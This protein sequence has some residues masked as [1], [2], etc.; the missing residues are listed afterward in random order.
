[1]KKFFLL[2]ALLC[3]LVVGSVSAQNMSIT[4][5]GIAS[6]QTVQIYS[7]NGSVLA[8]TYNTTTV[9]INLPLNDFVLLIKPDT[10]TVMTDPITL[11]GA[12]FAFVNT[13][14]I[15]IIIL[16]FFIGMVFRR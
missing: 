4:D 12:A 6:R 13:N 9:G 5:L 16:L 1:M 8:G 11:L 10:T 7:G 14:V 3:L 15:P 2:V